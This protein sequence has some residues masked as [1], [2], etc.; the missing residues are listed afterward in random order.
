[1]TW[2]LSLLLRIWFSYLGWN[3]ALLT[4]TAE[5]SPSPK[6][7][8]SNFSADW[9]VLLHLLLW[10]FEN[11][12]ASGFRFPNAKHAGDFITYPDFQ[13]PNLTTKP[14]TLPSASLSRASD[15]HTTADT[16][17]TCQTV[18]PGRAQQQPSA[19]SKGLHRLSWAGSPSAHCLVVAF[20]LPYADHEELQGRLTKINMSNAK[21]KED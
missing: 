10:C 11:V 20:R 9:L 8:L 21:L 5:L 13:Y 17:L 7:R 16:H 12:W 14:E 4:R 19:I 18:S 2:S 3:K 15:T 1:M 6:K